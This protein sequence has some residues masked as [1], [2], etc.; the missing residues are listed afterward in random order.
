MW[1]QVSSWLRFWAARIQCLILANVCSMG[2]RSGE[3]GGR[4]QRRAPAA[5]I[6][7]RTTWDLWLPRLSMTTIS[8]GS[9]LGTSCWRTR[10]EEHTSEL[11]SL[12]RISYAVFCLTKQTTRITHTYT[13]RLLYYHNSQISLSK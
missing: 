10:S 12:M 4:N 1:R 9:R 3:Y 5:L 6:A 2:L 8:P 13:Y 7:S 11:Q